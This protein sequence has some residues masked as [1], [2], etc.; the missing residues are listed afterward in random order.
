ME[1]K[2]YLDKVLGSLVRGTKI[3]YG[4]G[5]VYTP[6]S[7]PSYLLFSSSFFSSFPSF[8]FS[9]PFTKYCVNHFGLTEEEIEYVWDKYKDII[10]DKI[11]K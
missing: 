11:R 9:L 1:N 4:T 2:K 3:D 6:F 7:S 8:S 5:R 10:K